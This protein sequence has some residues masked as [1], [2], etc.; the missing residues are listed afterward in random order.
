MGVKGSSAVVPHDSNGCRNGC[1]GA[2]ESCKPPAISRQIAVGPRVRRA[3]RAIPLSSEVGNWSTPSGIS[4][5]FG[6]IN[7]KL[8]I[9][10]LPVQPPAC[11][12]RFTDCEAHV[13]PAY[14][15]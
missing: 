7:Q 12:V 3:I 5:N 10:G 15:K 4:R 2:H 6:Q 13:D 11:E 1:D 14:R 8:L 9:I